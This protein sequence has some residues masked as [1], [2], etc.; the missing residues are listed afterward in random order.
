MSE[1]IKMLSN[2]QLDSVIQ[3]SQGLYNG[4]NNGYGIFANPYSQYRNLLSINN[5]PAKP[6]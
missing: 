4:F 6:T 3:F 1:E 2:D 5:N